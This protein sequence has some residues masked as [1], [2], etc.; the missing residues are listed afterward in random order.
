MQCRLIKRCS[1]ARGRAAQQLE[2]TPTNSGKGRSVALNP[3]DKSTPLP[4]SHVP[5]ECVSLLLEAQVSGTALRG[6][7]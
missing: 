4:P 2:G 3:L 6:S 5:L 7:E 1:A